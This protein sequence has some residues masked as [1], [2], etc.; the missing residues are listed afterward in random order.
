MEKIGIVV[1][2]GCDVGNV[3][4]PLKVVPLRIFVN[5]KEYNDG[6][7]DEEF[8][9]ENLD[10]EVK[11]S[12]PNPEAIR[13]VMLDFINEGYKKIITFNISSNLSGTFNLFRLISQE[14]MEKFDDVKIVNID[15][16]NISV[17]SGLIVRKC[18][19]YIHSGSLFEDVV[20]KSKE[21]IEKSK[22][23][24]VIPTLKYLARGGRIG[25]V[26]AMLGEFLKMKPVISVNKEG[27]YYTVT[28]AHGFKKSINAMYEEFL[29]FVSN[30]KFISIVATTG[31]SESVKR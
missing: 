13:Q 30:K 23:F 26:K 15:T 28:K 21:D 22:V 18:I 11:T 10:G 6:E 14:L 9:F 7:I 8:L 19:E 4:Y 31:N 5:G 12:L 1:D 24:Y 3:D 25:K 29:K 20:E 16:L 2:S 27:E 17:G